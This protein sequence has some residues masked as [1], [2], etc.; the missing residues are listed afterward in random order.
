MNTNTSQYFYLIA[1]N[2]TNGSGCM[3]ASFNQPIA[4]PEQ[5]K[6]VI[7]MVQEANIGTPVCLT[8]IQ[9]LSAPD[10]SRDRV[11]LESLH[12]QLSDV[13]DWAG[14]QFNDEDADA[15]Q[16][17]E[18]LSEHLLAAFIKVKRHLNQS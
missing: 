13:A 5:V 4:T 14:N 10:R 11:F 18:N 1:Y 15:H 2:H 9:L 6:Q 7:S 16:L 8:N 12:K 17:A 3:T